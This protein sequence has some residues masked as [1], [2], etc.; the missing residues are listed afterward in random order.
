M[1]LVIGMQAIGC[2][3]FPGIDS[4]LH[5]PIQCF[6]YTYVW[7]LIPVPNCI[8]IFLRCLTGIVPDIIQQEYR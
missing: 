4:F 1:L 3:F 7:Y 6:F 5:F 2:Q 8:M